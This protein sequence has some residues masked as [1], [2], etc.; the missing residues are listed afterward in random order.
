MTATATK[1]PARTE[2]WV[3][4]PAGTPAGHCRGQAL[5]GSCHQRIYWVSVRGIRTPIDC[6]VPGGHAPSEAATTAQGDLFR[7]LTPVRDGLG[8]AHNEHCPDAARFARQAPA[9]RVWGMQP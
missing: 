8:V 5:G 6:E 9:A 1:I 7:S 4:V 2:R 3:T